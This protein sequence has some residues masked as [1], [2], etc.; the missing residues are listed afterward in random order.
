VRDH[1]VGHEHVVAGDEDGDGDNHDAEEVDAE[2]E[3][4]A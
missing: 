3:L 1:G 4:N 2:D